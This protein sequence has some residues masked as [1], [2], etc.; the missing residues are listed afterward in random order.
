MVESVLETIFVASFVGTVLVCLGFV[1]LPYRR[2]DSN[3]RMLLWGAFALATIVSATQLTILWSQL[4]TAVAGTTSG[5]GLGGTLNL[6]N[7]G[8]L[9][10]ESIEL[11]LLLVV[12]YFLYLWAYYR[13]RSRPFPGGQITHQ[14]QPVPRDAG[15]PD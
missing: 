8:A 14:R 5:G 6:V 13:I 3:S 9:Q 4:A 15:R 10:L 11:S 1:V 7:V 12:P 2:A